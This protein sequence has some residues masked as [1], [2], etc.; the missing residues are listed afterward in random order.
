MEGRKRE[1]KGDYVGMQLRI[2]GDRSG[3]W[4]FWRARPKSGRGIQRGIHDTG[5]VWFWRRCL[6]GGVSFL[7]IFYLK[8]SHLRNLGRRYKVTDMEY[9]NDR[10]MIPLSSY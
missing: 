5:G 9:H 6:I 4:F 2:D 1:K 7:A 10:I 3:R 8:K